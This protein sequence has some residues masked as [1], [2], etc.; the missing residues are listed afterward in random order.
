MGDEFSKDLCDK[1]RADVFNRIWNVMM[2]FTGIAITLAGGGAIF[3]YKTSVS[4]SLFEAKI[5]SIEKSI[6]KQQKANDE[7]FSDLKYELREMKKFFKGD[8]YAMQPEPPLPEYDDARNTF[9][10]FKGVKRE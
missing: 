8:G 7:N 9:T 10:N 1:Y 2:F 6:E 4:P 3:Q 5:A